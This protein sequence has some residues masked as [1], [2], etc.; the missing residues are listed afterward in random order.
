MPCS[1]GGSEMCFACPRVLIRVN[2]AR[3][4]EQVVSLIT[5]LGEMLI[6]ANECGLAETAGLDSKV[7]AS[8]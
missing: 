8:R 4:D 3:L 5:V 2:A 6:G 1:T 7:R